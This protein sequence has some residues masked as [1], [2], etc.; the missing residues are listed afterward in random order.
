MANSH[1]IYFRFFFFL[2][3][4]DRCQ[5]WGHSC[6]QSS[7]QAWGP[8]LDPKKILKKKKKKPVCVVGD[9]HLQCQRWGCRRKGRGTLVDQSNLPYLGNSRPVRWA[10]S[11]TKRWTMHTHAHTYSCM[12]ACTH[13]HA[14]MHMCGRAPI[15]TL[16]HTLNTHKI[17]VSLPYYFFSGASEQHITLCLWHDNFILFLC[18]LLHSFFFVCTYLCIFI[19]I[20]PILY[21]REYMW[22][23]L[24]Q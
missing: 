12:H 6:Q 8:E 17:N 23:W 13:T 18:F 5:G 21:S 15:H 2:M 1:K 22:M 14:C 10:V 4:T 11:K 7:W 20:L 9:V 24:L 3:N 19:C 16:P